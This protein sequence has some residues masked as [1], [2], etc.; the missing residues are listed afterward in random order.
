MSCR[1]VATWHAR[2]MLQN[3]WVGKLYH[4]NHRHRMLFYGGAS[5]SLLVLPG[6]LVRSCVANCL[7]TSQLLSLAWIQ[8]KQDCSILLSV[9]ALTHMDNIFCRIL[10]ILL[11]DRV[12]SVFSGRSSRIIYFMWLPTSMFPSSNSILTRL[13]IQMHLAHTICVAW[14]KNAKWTTSFLSQPIKL[15][16]PP[17]SWEHPSALEN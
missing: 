10:G 14:R 15:L 7:I 4:C 11:M 3:Y 6:Q 13:F 9:Y 1:Q 17:V 12:W 16:S 5:F 8:M 2:S